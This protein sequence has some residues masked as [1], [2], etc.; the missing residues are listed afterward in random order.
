MYGELCDCHSVEGDGV[1]DLLLKFSTP[2]LVDV[3]E[4]A[5]VTDRASVVLTVYGSLLDGTVFDASDC[6]WILS[7]GLRNE[8]SG[9]KSGRDGHPR[10]APDMQPIAPVP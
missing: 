6:V 4:L 7:G 5:S 3:L 8:G 2:E 10:A 1:N 9:R